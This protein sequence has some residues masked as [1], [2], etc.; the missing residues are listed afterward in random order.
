MLFPQLVCFWTGFLYTSLELSVMK[1]ADIH[2]QAFKELLYGSYRFR[3][4]GFLSS[5]HPRAE[6]TNPSQD[7][8]NT[9]VTGPESKRGDFFLLSLSVSHCNAFCLISPMKKCL[10]SNL[11]DF[12][13]GL[14][15]ISC[16]I[17]W[18]S[19]L[20]LLTK[21]VSGY[22]QISRHVSC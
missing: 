21:F 13:S 3:H 10:T 11:S 1:A 5:W 8:N 4:L 19:D 2:M 22:H 15:I 12:L 20:I 14:R 18:Q 16:H 9:C 6:R 17:L 7:G